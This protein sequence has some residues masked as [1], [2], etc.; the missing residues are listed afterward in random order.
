METEKETEPILSWF[1]ADIKPDD[2]EFEWDYFLEQLDE[3]I[4]E[5]NPEGLWFCS[6]ENFGWLRQSA[7][8][9]LE[10]KTGQDL[11]YKVLP[12]A[13]CSF[14]IFRE[15]NILKIQN[16]HHDS[17]TGNEMYQLI[18]ITEEQFANREL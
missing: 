13:D 17:P 18:P 9:F 11:V 12:K 14:N 5:M 3:L 4:K 6:V 15:N 8:I 7:R 1:S 2:V 16:F 10:F